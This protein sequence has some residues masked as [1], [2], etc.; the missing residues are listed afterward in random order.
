MINEA[1]N[2]TESSASI[3]DLINVSNK[4]SDDIFGVGEPF[5]M[6]DIRNHCPIFCIL[7]SKSIL[8]N[9]FPETFGYTT[10]VIMTTFDR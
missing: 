2:F 10:K 7:S 4:N 3:I 8:S 6:Q 5:V 1:T 9:L